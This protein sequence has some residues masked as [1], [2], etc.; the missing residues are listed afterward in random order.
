MSEQAPGAPPRVQVLAT[1][2]DRT[3]SREDLGLD[4]EAVRLVGDLRAAGVLV[5]LATGR[6]E[7]EV[8]SKPGLAGVF[9]AYVLECGARAGRWG[10]LHDANVSLA[11]IDAL[12]R[13]LKEAGIDVWRGPM[14]A[15]IARTDQEA[16][17]PLALRH[18]VTL[19][20]NKDRVDLVPAGIDKGV[21]LA[22]A[23][24]QLAPGR[25]PVVAAIG[26]GENDLGLLRAADHRVAVANAV[27]A[28]R[29]L[30]HEVAPLAASEGFKWFARRLLDD[31]ARAGRRAHGRDEA[32]EVEA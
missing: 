25:R 18:A 8:Q 4:D 28:L 27:P 31:L 26:D 2:L 32:R 14:S 6:T 9:D 7:G 1:D 3:F 17:A 23:L 15:S 24:E 5:I 16:A 21:G 20:P 10:A 19:L 22:R 30:A 11:G 29:D 12:C 13:H